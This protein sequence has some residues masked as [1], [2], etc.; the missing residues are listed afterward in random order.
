M[1]SDLLYN[2]NGMQSDVGSRHVLVETRR[3]FYLL[4]LCKQLMA[5]TTAMLGYPFPSIL[6]IRESF[7]SRDTESREDQKSVCEFRTSVLPSSVSVFSDSD[8]GRPRG[9]RCMTGASLEQ[10]DIRSEHL[11]YSKLSLSRL[12]RIADA[13]RDQRRL[14]HDLQCPSS[15][16]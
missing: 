9:C 13:P 8:F 1:L 11:I 10:T 15:L 6:P 12:Q 16:Q 3:T 7:K 5:S 14:D 4:I 2:V